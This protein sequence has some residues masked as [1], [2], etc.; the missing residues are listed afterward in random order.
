ML[1]YVLCYPYVN[2]TWV[3][4]INQLLDTLPTMPATL[5]AFCF[6]AVKPNFVF[7]LCFEGVCSL[8]RQ[9]CHGTW[10]SNSQH[11]WRWPWT[12]DPLASIPP[13]A[14][15]VGKYHHGRLH[16]NSFGYGLAYLRA[17]AS[18]PACSFLY[19]LL[20]KM[21]KWNCEQNKPFPPTCFGH[22]VSSQ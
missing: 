22:G 19:W 1:L 11:S 3:S 10:P 13:R 2:L 9:G 14:S 8:L 15:M 21:N 16:I 6:E 7:I 18:A 5:C 4:M 20:L 12:L 17:S